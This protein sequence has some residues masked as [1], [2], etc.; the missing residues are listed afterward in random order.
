M[1]NKDDRKIIAFG[2]DVHK[3]LSEGLG[4]GV[5]V[6]GESLGPSGSNVLIERKFRTPISVDDG[7]TALQ[8]LI[9]DDELQNLGIT[10]LVDAANKTS[11]H[12]GDG[13][14]TTVV[15]TEAIY[16][17]GRKLVGEFGFGKTPLE[18]KKAIFEA[19]DIVLEKLKGLTKTINT[20][21]EIKSVALAAYADGKMADIVSDMVEK[22]GENGVVIVEEGWGRETEIELL[23]GMRFAAKLAH[24]F[25][26][27]TPEEGLNLEGYPIL[28]SDFDFVNIDDLQAIVKDVS[29]AGENG[30]VVIA[31]KYENAA[32]AQTI[33][34]NMF[35][36][37]NRSTFKIYLV[38]TPSFTPSE[39]EDLAIFLGAKYFSKEKGDKALEATIHEL[40]RANIFKVSKMGVGEGIAIGGAGKKED[41]NKRIFELKLKLADEKVKLTKNRTTQEIASLAS[42]IGIIK[43]AS[44]SDGETEHIRLKTRNAVKSSQAAR[45]EGVVRGGGLALKE[46]AESLPDDN[47]LKEALKVSYEIIQRNAGGKLEISEELYDAVKVVR[48]TIE[49]A[50]STAWLLINTRTIIAFKSERQAEDAAEIIREGLRE[51]KGVRKS[52]YE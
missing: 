16:R 46:I 49:Q 31:N 4:I 6:A 15:L 18:I 26:A 3:K 39:Y 38:R 34:I 43:V 41:V 33:R 1:V 19:R 13:T 40:G 14:S 21:E 11:E 25:F 48:T 47:I 23:T 24:G 42:A 29:A 10:S 28:V 52:E 51:V 30:L 50:C 32:I 35:N 44:P 37:Q 5:R 22:V 9:L 7:I 36:A 17:A 20:K 8:N 2:D 27:N 45:E 12:V